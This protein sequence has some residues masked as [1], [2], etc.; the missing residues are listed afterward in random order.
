MGRRVLRKDIWRRQDPKTIAAVL[1][2]FPLPGT[3]NNP[4][5][6]LTTMIKIISHNDVDSK[7][8]VGLGL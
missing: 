5:S 4:E 1:Y 7:W 2:Q 6:Y 3:A 8:K